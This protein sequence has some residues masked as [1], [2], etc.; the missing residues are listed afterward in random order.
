M[1]IRDRVVIVTGASAGIGRATALRLAADGARVVLAA[2]TVAAMDVLACE[3]RTA[4]GDALVVPTDMR[5]LAAVASM[6]E[7]AFA[8]HGRLDVLVNNAGQAAAGTVAQ[9]SLDD[10]RKIVELNLYGP[11]AAIQ[12]AVPRMRQGG[13]GIVVNVSSMVTRMTLPAL[14]AYASTKSAL[15]MLSATARIELAPDNIRVLTVF[16]RM[17]ATDFGRNSLGDRATR[18]GQRSGPPPGVPVDPPEHVADRIA[19]AIRDE[20]A[21]TTMD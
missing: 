16:P 6:V 10:Y 8:W 7:R 12:A 15:N 5:D 20:A 11:I 9:F 19:R 3:V 14:A 21:E 4:G 2:R 18:K 17:T 1:D 13:G